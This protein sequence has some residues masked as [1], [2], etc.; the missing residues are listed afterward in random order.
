M[1][2]D[3]AKGTMKKMTG[4]TKEAAGKMTGNVGLQAKGAAEKAA[5]KMQDAAG[6]AKDTMR[7]QARRNP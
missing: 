1:D 3:R 2:K 5:G 4:A 7:E 6:K